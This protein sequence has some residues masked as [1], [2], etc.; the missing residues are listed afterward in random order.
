MYNIKNLTL[1]VY[2]S[3][4]LVL[5]KQIPAEWFPFVHQTY[6]NDPL[7]SSF[8]KVVNQSGV[9]Y[10]LTND[11]T[12]PIIDS[13][14]PAQLSQRIYTALSKSKE[15][16]IRA[17]QEALELEA[18]MKEQALIAEKNIEL[19]IEE[20][21]KGLELLSAELIENQKKY[22][23][24][25]DAKFQEMI[26]QQRQ[27]ELN[28]I[29]LKQEYDTRIDQL[30]AELLPALRD[31][32]E[33]VLDVLQSDLMEFE[34]THIAV[35]EAIDASDEAC[36]LV[37]MSPEHLWTRNFIIMRSIILKVTYNKTLAQLIGNVFPP[38]H[39]LISMLNKVGR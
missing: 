20:S 28:A 8:V 17:K 9:E 10:T 12:D 1:S 24:E 35:A 21:K 26:E 4:Q 23:S 2:R 29:K 27:A 18:R 33:T 37:I 13:Q 25:A 31:N 39:L 6:L 5:T 36:K 38:D 30:S 3:N 11:P 16:I 22:Q 19:A 14:N 15:D 34:S 7:E 32:P